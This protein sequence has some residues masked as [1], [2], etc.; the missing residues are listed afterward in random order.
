M[1]PTHFIIHTIQVKPGTID[2]AR[3]LFEEK[4][5]QIA[6]H[7]AAW[8]GARLTADREKNQIVTIGAWGD[9]EQMEAFLQQPAFNEAMAGFAEFFAGPPQTTITEVVTEVGPRS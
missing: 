3:E 4:V 2:S 8:C 5:P 9:V 6:G 1:T 7:F